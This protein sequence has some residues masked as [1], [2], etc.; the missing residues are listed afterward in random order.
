MRGKRTWEQLPQRARRAI[1]LAQTVDGL[2]RLA[3]MVDVARR[4]AE[5]VRGPKPVWVAALAV[6]G[7]LGLLPAVYFWRGRRPTGPAPRPASTRA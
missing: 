6:V 1:V 4:P 3:A 2:L 5:A 7:S